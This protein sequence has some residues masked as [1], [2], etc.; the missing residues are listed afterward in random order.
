MFQNQDLIVTL[1][2]VSA[3]LK[4]YINKAREEGVPAWV[5]ASGLHSR[6]IYEHVGFRFVEEVKIGAGEANK[7]GYRAEG[8]EGVSLYAMIFEP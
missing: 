2:A 4:T 8:G 5:E 3:L 1:G 7:D 6:A